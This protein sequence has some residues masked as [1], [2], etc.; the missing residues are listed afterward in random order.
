MQ[1]ENLKTK[2]IFFAQ[3]CMKKTIL[4][5]LLIVTGL[6]LTAQQALYTVQES[7]FEKVKIRFNTP[8]LQVSTKKSEGVFYSL[9]EMDGYFSSSTVGSPQLPVLGKTI[10]IPLC[11]DI[12]I[13]VLSASYNTYSTEE[14][15]IRYE[16]YPAQMS[17]AKSY[18]AP[19]EFFKT[20]SVYQNNAFYGEP[21]ARVEKVGVLR[22]INMANLYIAPVQYNPV[23][24]QIKIYHDIEIAISYQNADIPATCE[25]KNLHTNG[26]FLG[27]QS[28]LVA[29]PIAPL[30][31]DAITAAP[32]K[33]LIVAH[34][35][36]RGQLDEFIRWK[37][38]KGFL[39]EVAYTDDSG[40]GTTNTAIKN[41]IKSKYTG[42]TPQNPAPS[43]VLLVGDVQQIPAFP[44]KDHV[45]DLDYFLWTDGDNIPDCYYGRFSA[46]NI[47]QLTPQIAKTLQVEQY[48][49]PDPSYLAN[50]VLVAGAD[51]TYGPTHANGQ[52]NYLSNNYVN[53]TYGYNTVYKYLHPASSQAA[54]I[55]ANL[56]TGVGYANYTAHCKSAGWSD[57]LFEKSHINAMTN[58]NKYGF[59]IGNCCQSSKFDDNECFAEAIVRT[60]QKG[61]VAY[62]GGSDLT[63]WDEDFYWAVGVRSD[64]KNIPKANPVYD[65]AKLGAYD[66]L[67]HTHGEPYSQWFTSAGAIITAGNM[68]VQSSTSSRKDYYWQIYN[69]MGDP[70]LMP[71]LSIPQN[72]NID[73]SEELIAGVTFMEVQAAPYSYVALTS[74]NELV[75]AAFAD[76]AG[77]ATL[78]FQPLT[79]GE[80]EVTASAQNYIT[81]FKTVRVV[82]A[83]G[84]YAIVSSLALSQASIPQIGATVSLDLKIKNIGVSAISNMYA[85]LHTT[86]S[87]VT[88]TID[89]L[90]IDSLAVGQEREFN[91]TFAADV[92]SCFLDGIPANFFV[93]LYFDTNQSQKRLNV[94]LLAPKLERDG[95]HIQE[96]EGNHNGIINPGETFRIT[97]SNKNTG[98]AELTTVQSSLI[99][100][101]TKITIDERNQDIP[102]IGIN[103]SSETSFIVHFDNSVTEGEIY[104]F[105]YRIK[106]DEYVLYD[107][108]ILTVGQTVENFESNNFTVFPWVNST[109]H[110][111]S[112]ISTG[113]CEGRYC[114][115]SK[116]NLP[117]KTTSEL[118][119]TLN[120]AI[121]SE[122]SYFRKVS[123]E[124]EY[125]F[126]KFFIDNDEKE[127]LSGETGWEKV[128]FPVSSGQHTFRFQYVKDPSQFEGAD[129][130]WIDNIIFP[131]FGTLAQEDTI[132]CF[133]GEVIA[134]QENDR[135]PAVSVYPNP[136]RERVSIVSGAPIESIT[137]FDIHGRV[138]S[139]FTEK[140]EKMLEIDVNGFSKGFYMMKIQHANKT[141]VIRKLIKN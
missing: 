63:Y 53:T 19:V 8:D 137:I 57:P 78:S 35:M 34:A 44:Y 121:D 86:S 122:I 26:L 88:V 129:C 116:Q 45:S 6:S 24:R 13:E 29:N 21:L 41:F 70:S 132:Y 33:Y 46:Q 42:A 18:D 138:V 133:P 30:K 72:M 59:F 27:S 99:A 114:A 102:S 16:V 43:Y 66:R 126:F 23:T 10:E 97:L 92:A 36:F 119:I 120:V 11:E 103:Q 2:N 48:T 123:S 105:Y 101:Y 89:S 104:R 14:L 77:N 61:A 135:L 96:M 90:F 67:F 38:R 71:Y 52:V 84:A 140:A 79:L 124:S 76:N 134:I 47:N 28:A 98:H 65:A 141:T 7:S 1:P 117:N 74:Q 68:A 55:R 108:F 49:M 32:V 107:T 130:A 106:K 56:N 20:A 125:D 50:A 69:L 62:I 9:L 5:F 39:V 37:K 139:F 94:T 110:P 60:P 91:E 64:I 95:F 80:Y 75:A 83:F 111:W 113:A 58:A 40:V 136:A 112:I 73:C 118:K 12:R 17:Y 31:R 100:N 131:V 25:M 85:K 3:F 128:T 127:N 22:N 4:L 15:D 87:N 82:D 54:A 51:P 93:T 115:R 81:T 109:T